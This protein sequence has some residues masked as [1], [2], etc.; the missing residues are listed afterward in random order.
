[1]VTLKI[2][3]ELKEYIESGVACLVATGDANGRPLVRMGWG[4]TVRDDG[5]TIDVYLDAARAERTLT[6]LEEN[7]RIAMT[8]AHPVNYR[9]AQFKGRL[10]GTG[11]PTD[12]E[13]KRVEQH[14]SDFTVSTSLIGD[15]PD[16]IAN[17]WLQDVVRISFVVEQAFDQTPGPEAGKPL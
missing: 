9:S 12:D 15:P 7:G 14:R 5:E 11:K 13:R 16:I 4:P 3:G 6:N 10:V 8:V 1:M 17:L 2:E